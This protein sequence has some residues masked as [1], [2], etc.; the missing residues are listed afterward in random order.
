MY[1]PD[2][3]ICIWMSQILKKI[4]QFGQVWKFQKL[5]QDNITERSTYHANKICLRKQKSYKHE[6]R[7]CFIP[8]N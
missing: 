3:V 2:T 8:S 4:K 6:L 5:I 1:F 7:G